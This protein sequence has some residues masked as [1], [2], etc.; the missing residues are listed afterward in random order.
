MP[1]RLKLYEA[2]VSPEELAAAERRFRDALE[3]VLG[4]EDMVLPV[5]AA[6]QR[7]V[8][9]HGEQFDEEVL[10]DSERMVFTQWREAELAAVAAA[11]GP[12]RYM[13]DAMYEIGD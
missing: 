8:G 1:Y 11:F 9:M 13:G 6:Y 2:D 7:I 3:E 12:N 5:H 10:S 4:S